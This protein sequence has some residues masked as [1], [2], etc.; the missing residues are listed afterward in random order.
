MLGSISG[1]ALLALFPNRPLRNKACTP[2]F[3][4]LT[5]HGN[6]SQWTTCRASLSTKWGNGSVF[7]VVDRFSKMAILATYKKII[8]TE[9][10]A[11]IFFE[12]VWVHF[13]IPT[14]P[15][16]GCGRLSYAGLG[17]SYV[18]HRGDSHPMCEGSW[19]YTCTGYAQSFDL[20]P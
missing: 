20:R 15:E 9:A 18:E 5:G 3:L 2:L 10:T 14:P 6:P 7:V 4:L 19:N 11:K 17:C 1:L 12:K 16:K 13:G 8:T